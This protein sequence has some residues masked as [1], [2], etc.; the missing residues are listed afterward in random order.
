MYYSTTN[1]QVAMVGGYIGEVLILPNQ[2]R[3]AIKI[4]M[5]LVPK[6][7]VIVYYFGKSDDKL[8]KKFGYDS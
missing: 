6:R 8:K 3:N 5:G 1:Q 7:P 2:L 4:A